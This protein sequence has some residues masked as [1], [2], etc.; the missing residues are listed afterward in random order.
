M[1]GRAEDYERTTGFAEIAL[2]QMK[3]LRHANSPRNYE[4]W[5]TYATGH[6]PALNAQIN[7]MLKANGIACGIHYPIA[8]PCLNAYRSLGLSESDFPEA[9]KASREI[10]SLPMFPELSGDAVDY[11]AETLR[12]A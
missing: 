10:L 12:R 9:V 1:T 4:I 11:I 2:G 8:I 7:S 3:A 5:Y 6:H